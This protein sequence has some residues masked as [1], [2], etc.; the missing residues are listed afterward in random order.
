MQRIPTEEL[1]SDIQDVAHRCGEPLSI[2]TYREHGSHSPTTIQRRLGSWSE[3]LNEA[4]VEGFENP[5]K[6]PADEV[7]A[8]LQEV[9]D[10]HGGKVTGSIYR[11]HG[12]Y[13]ISTIRSRFGT[14][15]DALDAA[16]I[17]VSFERDI[18]TADL[19]EDLLNVAEKLGRTPSQ[20]QYSEYGKHSQSTQQRHFGS[21]NGAI[22]AAGLEINE[23]YDEKQISKEELVDDIQQVAHQLQKTPT[24]EE[25]DKDGSYSIGSVCLR[26]GSWN[27][28]LREAGFEPTKLHDIDPVDILKDIRRV[29]EDGIGPSIQKYR[30]DGEYSS[31][32]A[33]DM[34]GRWWRAVVLAGLKPEK[35]RPL[36]PSTVDRY[37]KQVR[38]SP[39]TD[40]FPILLFMFSGM[41][42]HTALEMSHDWLRHNRDRNIV[43]VPP[44]HASGTDPWL[45]RMPETWHNPHTGERIPTTL[46]EVAEWVLDYHDEMP[47]ESPSGLEEKCR[48]VALKANIENRE[49]K[50]YGQTKRD[51]P[52]PVIRPADLAY[53]HG[54]NLCRQGISSEVI[55]RRLGIDGYRGRFT[56]DDLM[57]WTYIREDVVHDEF[58]PP[59]VILDPV[60]P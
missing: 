23:S 6:V 16:G 59:D 60:S 27:N 58:E 38:D 24:G 5:T 32:P 54:V 46:P 36:E 11:K 44:E 55:R 57:L 9:A 19:I 41:S 26:F 28:G 25:Y 52:E 21:W 7:L 18:S 10:E 33:R 4:E 42:K 3:A 22:R 50:Y 45:L 51:D 14:Y 17:E 37:F 13:S 56:V 53:T 29:A 49:S 39:P 2:S 1:L 43:R 8:D 15:N 47:Y 30:S 31:Q 34:F 20:S 12:K 40:A 35:R 48:R